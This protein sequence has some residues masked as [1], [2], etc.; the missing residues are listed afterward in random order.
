M[1]LTDWCKPVNKT[2]KIL[3]YNKSD[4]APFYNA[5]MEGD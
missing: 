4:S 5:E 2:H 3:K 1:N